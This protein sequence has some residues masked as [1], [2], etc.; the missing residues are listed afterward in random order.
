MGLFCIDHDA[1]PGVEFVRGR[2]WPP[3]AR[4]AHAVAPRL[5]AAAKQ[6]RVPVRPAA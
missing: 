4:L 3:S 6:P 5:I 1:P 2:P